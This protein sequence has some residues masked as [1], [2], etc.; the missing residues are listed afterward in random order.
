MNPNKWENLIFLA[1]EKFGIDKKYEEKFEVTTTSTGEKI[2]GKR[3]I[4]EF[5]APFGRIMLEK[6]SKPKV[7]DKK[8]LHTKRIGGRTAFDFVYSD[9]E[10]VVVLNLYKKSEDGEWEEMSPE[11]MGIS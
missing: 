10:K 3:E 6:I 4:V 7:I 9:S 5:E 11:T 8:I 1:E 2:M